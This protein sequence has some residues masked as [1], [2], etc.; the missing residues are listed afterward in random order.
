MSL[1]RLIEDYYAARSAH[2]EANARKAAAYERMKEAERAV[3]TAMI[4]EEQQ[5]VKR[6]DG[7]T[8]YLRR[9]VSLSVTQEN[10]PMIRQWLMDTVGDDADFVREE[11][12]KKAVADLVKSQLEGGADEDEFP[13]FLRLSTFPNL[14][15]N[16]WNNRR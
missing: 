3:V 4:D 11:V 8:V 15:V 9:A 12:Q 7:T 14:S 16:G 10:S 2:D 5:S 1:S 6:T 13:D